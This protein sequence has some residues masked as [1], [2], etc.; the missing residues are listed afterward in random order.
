MANQY[1]SV[2]KEKKKYE[3]VV[4]DRHFL[5][6][7]ALSIDFILIFLLLVVSFGIYFFTVLSP[8]SMIVSDVL[9]FLDS[10]SVIYDQFDFE[11]ACQEEVHLEGDVSLE[12]DSN[13]D[14]KE[15]MDFLK[16]LQFDYSF[17]DDGVVKWLEISGS[18]ADFSY[19]ED[20]S[21]G[22]FVSD[23][24]NILYDLEQDGSLY[25]S[26]AGLDMN[27]ENFLE[28]ELGNIEF[29]Q[30]VFVSDGELVVSVD[31]NLAG[32]KVKA[33]L[34]RL[35][36]GNSDFVS[37]LSSYVS[38][39]ATY[40]FTFKN[41]VFSND[42]ISFKMVIRDGDYRGV[43][44]FSDSVFEYSDADSTYQGVLKVED[45]DFS[46]RFYEGEEMKFIVSGKGND[47]SYVY[48]YQVINV[49]DNL[50]LQIKKEDLEN[51]YTVNIKKEDEDK[52]L[53]LLATIHLK[54]DSN[55]L[56][57]DGILDNEFVSYSQLGD[58]KKSEIDR[59]TYRLVNG[60][61]N[62][63]EYVQVSVNFL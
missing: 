3:D 33:M 23:D 54:Y 44:T 55:V 59:Y 24:D 51:I 6:R 58:E 61:S 28:E 34:S 36:S 25:F 50:S 7:H 16:N 4:D 60:L 11:D 45:D 30:S 38:N 5:R 47:T 52:Y 39:S 46:F 27:I 29:N 42:L 22:Y 1:D 2:L 10:V 20:V 37:S 56:I 48:T 57:D 8:S 40:E 12:V 43:L 53:N 19:Y 41:E 62:L 35:D 31:F 21:N 15:D 49:V 13:Y 18:D 26:Y 32:D 17:M 14:N 9:E 63:F